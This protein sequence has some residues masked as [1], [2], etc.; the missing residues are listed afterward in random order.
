MGDTESVEIF[1][2]PLTPRRK[3]D[4]VPKSNF[5]QFSSVQ[6]LRAEFVE[7]LGVGLHEADEIF[8]VEDAEAAVVGGAFSETFHAVPA[9]NFAGD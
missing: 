4:S 3:R 5:S 1:R 7:A 6:F 2:P 9:G 8:R